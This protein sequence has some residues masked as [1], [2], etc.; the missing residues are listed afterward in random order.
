M[1]SG[2]GWQTYWYVGQSRDC[3]GNYG[4]MTECQGRESGEGEREGGGGGGGGEK[5][6]GRELEEGR[7][8][9]VGKREKGS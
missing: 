5:D 3:Q 9:G 4:E 8:S 7:E 2:I 1:S 6:L